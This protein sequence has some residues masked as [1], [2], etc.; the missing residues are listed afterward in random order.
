MIIF[1]IMNTKRDYSLCYSIIQ[2]IEQKSPFSFEE[3]VSVCIFD[4]EDL[5]PLEG[6]KNVE[7]RWNKLS[8]YNIKC[9]NDIEGLI[10]G[11]EK[12]TADIFYFR[13]YYKYS[14]D[15]TDL[16]YFELLLHQYLKRCYLCVHYEKQED[17]FRV[18]QFY[19]IESHD[20]F[21]TETYNYRFHYWTAN[22]SD[23][24]RITRLS[25]EFKDKRA[26]ST[27]TFFPLLRVEKNSYSVLAQSVLQL[28]DGMDFLAP[29]TIEEAR[30]KAITSPKTALRAYCSRITEFT[31]KRKEL[32]S[33]IEEPKLKRAMENSSVLA[34]SLFLS[35]VHI[36]TSTQTKEQK[37]LKPY[38]LQNLLLDAE[39]FADGTLQIIENAYL[40]AK[41]GFFCFR[42][43]K[44]KE[45]AEYLK[46]HYGVIPAD[47]LYHL[48][49]LVSDN[50]KAEQMDIP[51]QFV[52][53]FEK[54]LRNQ[55]F[56][57][58][59]IDKKV[60]K[61]NNLQLKDFFSPS[62][63][64]KEFWDEYYDSSENIALHYGLNVFDHVVRFADGVFHL[65][66][67]GI[68]FAIPSKI[69]ASNE[70]T[71]PE[72]QPH[73]PGTQY[74]VL[75]P[76]QY[77]RNLKQTTGIGA[78]PNYRAL[79]QR[80]WRQVDVN[81]TE[82][83]K[84]L[85]GFS[86]FYDIE[87]KNRKV[88]EICNLLSSAVEENEIKTGREILTLDVEKVD[89]PQQCELFSKSWISYIGRDGRKFK[90]VAI[91]NA[92]N[93]FL[94]SFIKFFGTLFYKKDYCSFLKNHEIYLCGSD[95][96]RAIEFYGDTIFDAIA[97]TKY[98]FDKKGEFPWEL[99]MLHRIAEKCEKRYSKKKST[100][101]LLPFDLLIRKNDDQGRSVTL[102]EQKVVFDLENDLQEQAFGGRLS[103][104]HMGVG[105]K[106]HV[107]DN[108]YEAV[109][110]FGAKYYVSHFA[111]LLAE[112]I[113]KKKF[114]KNKTRKIILVGYE[115]YSELL[116]I[117]LKERLEGTK[118]EK[119]DYVIYEGNNEEPNRFRRKDIVNLNKETAKEMSFVIVVPIGS[120][121]ATHDKIIA[122]M[123]RNFCDSISGGG[124]LKQILANLCVVLVR[125]DKISNP[126]GEAIQDTFW[127]ESSSF[128]KIVKL[129]KKK[130]EVD[131]SGDNPVHYFDI[132]DDNQVHY[133]AWA[134][135]KWRA[136]DSCM[137][138]FPDPFD[139]EEPKK[140]TDEEPVM[141]V[142]RASVVPLI[143][144]DPFEEK[145][146]LVEKNVKKSDACFGGDISWL[147]VDRVLKY[148]HHRRN[149]NHFEY[150]FD[151]EELMDSIQRDSEKIKVLEEWLEIIGSTYKGSSEEEKLV[152]DFIVAP[153]HMSNA[154]FVNN[155]RKYAFPSVSGVLWID[156]TRE[157]RS[158]IK[159]K[160]SFL[161]QLSTNLLFAG[162]KGE[163]NFHYVDDTITSGL[164]C[165]R[166]KN[167]LQSLFEQALL[168]GK[169]QDGVKVNL[170]RSIILLLNRCSN[171]TKLTYID[172]QNDFHGFIE[173]NIPAMRIHEDACTLCSREKSYK[174][175][176]EISATNILAN[177]FAEMA[178]ENKIHEVQK[179]KEIAFQ[180]ANPANYYY[181]MEYTHKINNRLKEIN[182]SALDRERN[183]EEVAQYFLTSL[184]KAISSE[185]NQSDKICA[186]LQVI[187][188]PFLS[189]RKIILEVAFPLLLK[190]THNI[191]VERLT[192]HNPEWRPLVSYV[193]GLEE[194]GDNEDLFRLL[195]E[196]L[197]ALSQLGANY[198]IRA[199][200]IN[201]FF[202]YIGNEKIFS[203]EKQ[204]E[205]IAIYAQVTKQTL[206][207][208]RQDNRS[209]RLEKLLFGKLREEERLLAEKPYIEELSEVMLI[210]NN[211]IIAN[212]LDRVQRE[213]NDV[214][215]D[216][217]I[218]I[219]SSV[220]DVLIKLSSVLEKSENSKR[221]IERVNITLIKILKQ[222]FCQSYV[223]LSEVEGN[224]PI[225]NPNRIRE[226]ALLDL[227]LIPDGSLAENRKE[228][229]KY[230]PVLLEQIR[231]I[232]EAKKVQLFMRAGD[233]NH[234]I[235]SNAHEN[236]EDEKYL[237]YINNLEEHISEKIIR[238]IGETYYRAD[239]NSEN[240]IHAIC[241]GKWFLVFEFRNQENKS[242][243]LLR[244]RDVL[245]MRQAL[246][247]RFS[248]DF[249]NNLF[250]EYISLQEKIR[251]LTKETA[252]SHTP[253]PEIRADVYALDKV[254]K[255][256]EITPDVRKGVAGQMK[257]LTDSLISKLFVCHIDDNRFP[258]DVRAWLNDRPD[259]TMLQ[260]MKEIL[261][262]AHEELVR[263][264]KNSYRHYANIN[265]NGLD[266]VEWMIRYVGVQKHRYIWYCIV[267]ATFMNAL[268]HGKFDD[269]PSDPKRRTVKI[270]VGVSDDEKYLIVSNDCKA[271]MNRHNEGIGIKAIQAYF[272][273]CGYEGFISDRDPNNK[274]KHIVKIPLTKE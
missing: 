22:K 170:F 145:L 96:Q 41:N 250:I 55:G 143:M 148:G 227:L 118:Y 159:A 137:E 231:L 72:V 57:Q 164:H 191:V 36:I 77:S 110:L 42:L 232:L 134:E 245:V 47:E 27:S 61:A 117:D 23:E 226:M 3:G 175:L 21:S 237:K 209:V 58:E 66:S 158:N 136:H 174:E 69:Y 162:R 160:Y 49:L 131:I 52:K 89:H 126:N 54:R 169:G 208:H 238:A 80:K 93:L 152:Y 188:S 150:Y 225:I 247:S 218:K 83:Y 92:S 99:E 212:T 204:R 116:M 60:D 252:G 124:F 258:E 30:Y 178:E 219:S 13:V 103:G 182:F 6:I 62:Q 202:E 133:Y 82:V 221:V 233:V 181:K 222:Y 24:R 94:M 235:T 5:T 34:F 259:V 121:L 76:I 242:D 100:L 196:L 168:R 16:H 73:I 190:L 269:D 28:Y 56:L 270:D 149:N 17:S 230:Y 87:A 112:T 207:F 154:S 203:P 9:E 244:V 193:E 271:P 185:S 165:R 213:L 31:L 251:H 64:A 141:K 201:S 223:T 184:N 122:D 205:W 10:V 98:L 132:G 46:E 113:K 234:Y 229:K 200:V 84:E 20:I 172:D 102:F 240:K 173:L 224:N 139:L 192:S 197:E 11:R 161:T 216:K 236:G 18:S 147:G 78:E 176:S 119:V 104:V 206:F 248:K 153:M 65:T 266:E 25:K 249:E 256:H 101:Q 45:R 120:A 257:Q 189:Y 265:F 263:I 125:N 74:R 44:P 95:A 210:E 109:L 33:Y 90:K 7:D 198:I 239:G 194:E 71:I 214:H 48:E 228:Q 91:I 195:K 26:Q 171:P 215:F 86:D 187:S 59:E 142:N 151:T 138:C 156:T 264:D 63:E 199:D 115:T 97:A 1:D 123:K 255:D 146:K 107:V 140:L 51:A 2:W 79:G 68:N 108:F 253:Y 29:D 217:S 267:Y 273:F 241:I 262:C 157:F 180:E 166:T 274:M 211:S 106:I 67:S 130:E 243:N 177:Q 85:E 186:F 14:H 272:T 268:R 38:E 88:Q 167:L 135:T 32:S 105:S 260:D 81:L 70:S 127:Q 35:F 37:Q 220:S 179:P 53:N 15:V 163:I 8:K 75:L 50:S 155:V 261:I 129:N 39:T 4:D 246:L 144:V 40:H 114:A 111:Y 128:E 12:A 254:L 43:Q 183:K 19:M